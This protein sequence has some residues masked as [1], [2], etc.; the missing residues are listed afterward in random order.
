MITKILQDFT[1]TPKKR[2]FIF[3]LFEITFVAYIIL[4]HFYFIN[5]FIAILSN[6][7]FEIMIAVNAWSTIWNTY[8]YHIENIEYSSVAHKKII[9]ILTGINII[10]SILIFFL[11]IGLGYCFYE[12]TFI[13]ISIIYWLYV[14]YFSKAYK[15]LPEE[16][17]K[18]T[19]T[20]ITNAINKP[21]NKSFDFMNKFEKK[22]DNFTN[23][24]EKKSENF[25][26][27]EDIIDKHKDNN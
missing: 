26:K 9:S 2:S 23:K 6:F 14:R 5:D 13:W 4:V 10:I 20:E 18:L 16:F 7:L 24:A 11:N 3:N 25:E 17:K 21:F 12:N 19:D 15:E 1:N 22:I 27:K 8:D